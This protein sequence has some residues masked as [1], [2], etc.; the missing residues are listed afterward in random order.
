M[1]SIWSHTPTNVRN[2]Y[3]SLNFFSTCIIIKQFIEWKLFRTILWR[4]N[5]FSIKKSEIKP[6]LPGFT[7]RFINSSALFFTLALTDQRSM[8]KFHRLLTGCFFVFNKTFFDEILFT[9]LFLLWLKISCV[10]GVTLSI[11]TVLAS[12]Y[13][14]IFSFLKSKEI[15]LDELR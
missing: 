12:Y 15:E 11:I 13:I 3:L 9:N 10:S 6:P 5:Q 8:T 4:W 2:H 7:L 1:F 14:V